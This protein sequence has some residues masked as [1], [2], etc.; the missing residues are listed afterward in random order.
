MSR[1]A[2]VQPKP[3]VGDRLK[4]YWSNT[5]DDVEFAVDSVQSKLPGA[6]RP[7]AIHP[8][9]R[10]ARAEEAYH[11]QLACA[12]S[13]SEA[14][15]QYQSARV[16]RTPSGPISAS[17]LVQ[18]M[19]TVGRINAEQGYSSP[20]RSSGKEKEPLLRANPAV[21]EDGDW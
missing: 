14:E 12:L 15:K 16:N 10:K 11:V 1:V 5:L 20:N 21:H 4:R 2:P 17:Q 18:T 13:A 9:A 8:A 7:P 19:P 6:N 3:P